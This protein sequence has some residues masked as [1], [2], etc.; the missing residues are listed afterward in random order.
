MRYTA[1]RR[2]EVKDVI[3]NLFSRLFYFLSVYKVV[4]PPVWVHRVCL[5]SN[6]VEQQYTI[7]VVDDFNAFIHDAVHNRAIQAKN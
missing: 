2:H 1:S 6:W 4:R 5:H 3:I 7:F